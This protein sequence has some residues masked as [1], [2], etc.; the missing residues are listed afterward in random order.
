MKINKSK[1]ESEISKTLGSTLNI[2]NLFAVPKIIKVVIS[3][4]VGKFKDDQNIINTIMADLALITGQKPKI[5]LSKKAVS[6]FKLRLKQPV[7]LTVTLRG[8]KMHDFIQRFS[9]IAIPRIR[10]FKGLSLR[11]LDDHGNY[12]LGIEEHTIMPEIK[13]DDVKQIYGFQVNIN[14]SAKNKD[15]AKALLTEYGFVFEKIN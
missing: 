9:Q 7:G 15:Q 13:Y 12:S 1:S 2:S 6:A 8:S 11:G 3:T 14:T 10:D 4:G 5:N